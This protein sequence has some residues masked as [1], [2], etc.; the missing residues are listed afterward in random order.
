MALTTMLGALKSGYVFITEKLLGR[1][2]H[3][4]ARLPGPTLSLTIPRSR[5]PKV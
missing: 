2:K 1:R 5:S 3:A 4:V